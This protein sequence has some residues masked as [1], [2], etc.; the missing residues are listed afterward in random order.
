MKSIDFTA[1]NLFKL[2][3][4]P[5]ILKT[6]FENWLLKNDDFVVDF[7]SKK[8]HIGKYELNRKLKFSLALIKKE[9]TDE[10]MSASE[11]DE[12]LFEIK[13]NLKPKLDKELS[14]FPDELKKEFLIKSLVS[15]GKKL[16][17]INDESIKS[18]SDNL[19]DGDL[20][21]DDLEPLIQNNR[22]VKD[23]MINFPNPYP[24]VFKDYY[25]YSVFIKLYDEFGNKK[26]CLS[27]Y[28]Y[29][30]YKMTYDGLI[31]FDLL[32]KS[33]IEMLSD[34]DISIDRIKPKGDIG[35]IALR[36]SIYSRVK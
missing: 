22:K 10:G 21:S 32:H 29:V 13:S 28:S 36:D 27:N 35:K 5:E 9:L 6:D 23:E 24:R 19:Y 30:F 31:H 17:K 1:E 7:D 33:Y 4:T 11:I 18:I 2:G 15:T 34:F 14:S 25:S 20:L 26:E 8:I 16:F 12:Y 3:L